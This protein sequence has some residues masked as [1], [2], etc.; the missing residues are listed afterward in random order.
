MTNPASLVS[1]IVTFHNEGLLAHYT[2]SNLEGIRQYS[3]ANGVLVELVLVLSC[4][5]TETI[6]VV[7]AHPSIKPNDQI[8]EINN[9][10]DLGAAR[11]MGIQS[12]KGTYIAIFDGDDYHSRNWLVEALKRAQT[13]PDNVIV[14]PELTISFGVSCGLY[15]MPDMQRI[16]YPLENLFSTNAWG[17]DS[18]GL[19]DI[20]IKHPYQHTYVMETGFGYE[21]WHWNLEL[22]AHG[23]RHVTALKT[24]LFY[25][26]KEVSL[27][28]TH[29]RTNSIIRPTKFFDRQ[30]AW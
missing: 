9:P 26:R 8:L 13:N 2:L 7:R 18:F 12:S 16:D 22:I 17:S 5:D 15:E 4:A 1:A 25:R 27:V 19:R 23:I 28:M 29:S 10:D 20:Y 14:H 6:R 21:D 3:Q 11:N 30:Q 24:A